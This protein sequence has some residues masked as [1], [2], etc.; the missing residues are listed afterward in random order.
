MINKALLLALLFYLLIAPNTTTSQQVETL[1]LAYIEFPPFTYTNKHGQADGLLLNKALKLITAAGYDYKTISL[2]AKRLKKSLI[3]GQVD[4]WLGIKKQK[5]L[6]TD[7]LIGEQEIGN[8]HV[9]I[10]AVNKGKITHLS[11]L[12]HHA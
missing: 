2:P 12:N 9:N 4:I 1:T 10:Y 7:V 6:G 3:K 11:E 5:E 8:V